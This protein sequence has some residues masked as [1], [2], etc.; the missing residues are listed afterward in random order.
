MRKM[1]LITVCV[2]MP[3]FAG[4]M[5]LSGLTTSATAGEAADLELTISGIAPIQGQIS[6][7]VFADK[8]GYKAGDDPIASAT[9][10]VDGESVTEVFSGLEAGDCAIK[11]F[12]DVN[13]NGKLDTNMIGIP[14][15]PFGFSNGAKARFGPP[16]F[17]DARFDLESGDNTHEIVMESAE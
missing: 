3:V 2:L 17:N 16:S 5:A 6:I 13:G 8:A 4:L 12:H 7:A 1:R 9:I 10:Q 11:I 15:E 14:T